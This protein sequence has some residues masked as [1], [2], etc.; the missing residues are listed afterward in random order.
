MLL[1]ELVFGTIKGEAP[2]S[3]CCVVVLLWLFGR[4]SSL[5][6]LAERLRLRQQL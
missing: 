5:R 1:N 4:G 3:I 6:S 2:D